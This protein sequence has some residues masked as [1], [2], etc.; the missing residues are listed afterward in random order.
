MLREIIQYIIIQ[1]LE[2]DLLVPPLKDVQ[3]ATVGQMLDKINKSRIKT[4]KPLGFQS[5]SSDSIKS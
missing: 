2:V 5:N 3:V 4:G 1:S